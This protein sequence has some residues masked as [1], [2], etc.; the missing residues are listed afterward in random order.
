MENKKRKLSGLILT[1]SALAGFASN[2]TT[3]TGAGFSDFLRNKVSNFK[4][5]TTNFGNKL[6]HTATS[7][8]FIDFFNSKIDKTKDVAMRVGGAVKNVVTKSII[9]VFLDKAAALS[10]SVRESVLTKYSADGKHNKYND[11]NE[12]NNGESKHENNLNSTSIKGKQLNENINNYIDLI[13]ERSAS[14]SISNIDVLIKNNDEFDENM[15]KCLLRIIRDDLNEKEAGIFS[16]FLSNLRENGIKIFSKLIKKSEKVTDSIWNLIGD[17]DKSAEN[18]GLLINGFDGSEDCL[19]KLAEFIVGTSFIEH[20]NE[21]GRKEFVS[22][23]AVLLRQEEFNQDIAKFVSTIFNSNSSDEK[24]NN[25]VNLK[26]MLNYEFFDDN[27]A[28]ELIKKI[29]DIGVIN[30]GKV[31]DSRIQD[32]KKSIEEEGKSIEN[33]KKLTTNNDEFDEIFAGHLI[34]FLKHDYNERESNNFSKLLA[35]LS[36]GGIKTF[37][38]LIKK[39]EEITHSIWNLFRESDDKSSENFGLLINEVNGSENSLKKL[40]QVIKETSEVEHEERSGG[41]ISENTLAILLKQKNFD[42][43]AAKNFSTLFNSD[44]FDVEDMY[45]FAKLINELCTG[46]IIDTRDT[47]AN[48]LVTLMKSKNFEEKHILKKFHDIFKIVKE[49]TEY[50]KYDVIGRLSDCLFT[51]KQFDEKSAEGLVTWLSDKNFDYNAFLSLLVKGEFRNRAAD[52]LVQLFKNE[53]IAQNFALLIKDK[54]FDASAFA[55]MVSNKAITEGTYTY[56]ADNLAKLLINENLDISKF[57]SMMLADEFSEEEFI[58]TL[59][60]S[61]FKADDFITEKDLQTKEVEKVIDIKDKKLSVEVKEVK[62]EVENLTHEGDKLKKKKDSKNFEKIKSNIIINDNGSNAKVIEK[63]KVLEQAPKTLDQKLINDKYKEQAFK[64]YNN[65]IKKLE[66]LGAEECLKNIK[67]Y[68]TKGVKNIKSSDNIEKQLDNNFFELLKY[69]I[70]DENSINNFASLL[71][72]MNITI[73]YLIN[74]I[75]KENI[76]NVSKFF[77]SKLTKK[78]NEFF[79]AFSLLQV[80]K[81]S[82]KALPKLFN[83]KNFDVDKFAS[84]VERFG[85]VKGFGSNDEPNYE[86]LSKLIIELGEHARENFIK[87]I[88][89]IDDD[90]F[91]EFEIL[92]NKVPTDTLVK[93]FNANN[94]ENYIDKIIE[95]FKEHDFEFVPSLMDNGF[96]EKNFEKILYGTG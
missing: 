4:D 11:V 30:I 17:C 15:A 5:I 42:Q 58:N 84:I 9:P 26:K 32:H 47:K 66:N 14:K 63:L 77:F 39:S 43:K 59:A 40:E 57:A 75:D 24:D 64:N 90:S 2:A 35:K 3:T 29:K 65:L 72:D 82:F 53:N 45:Y 60:K 89:N 34:K 78:M 83:S 93:L 61:D 44:N 27:Y 7:A 41:T 25:M 46:L 87:F 16:K 28:K 12:T 49:T 55:Y 79:S 81:S 31:L 22:K 8:K 1:G 68:L 13:K 38:K 10:G 95:K 6:S 91:E 48:N 94:F 21:Y 86:N 19:E 54:K 52:I 76:R 96:N 20:E 74:N 50:D 71:N 33:I 69:E 36:N 70:Y 62:H 88:N 56:F 18:F 37:S 51:S 73:I 23:F 85:I 67:L 80:R 92:I